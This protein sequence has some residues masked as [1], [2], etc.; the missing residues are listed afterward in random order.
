MVQGLARD[1]YMREYVVTGAVRPAP[2]QR[3]GVV[4]L[5]LTDAGATQ[6]A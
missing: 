6:V 5:V 1:S 4:E 2:T 3:S